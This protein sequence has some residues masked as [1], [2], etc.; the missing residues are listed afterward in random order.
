MLVLGVALLGSG[1]FSVYAQEK[2]AKYVF[3]FPSHIGAADPNMKVWTTA[4]K[5][6]E[7][8]YPEVKIRYF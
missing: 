6:F 7:S 1:I 3:Y 2:E 4:I 5:D 8:R